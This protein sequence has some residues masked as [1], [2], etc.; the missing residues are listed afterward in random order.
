M[1]TIKAKKAYLK[2]FG[3]IVGKRDPRLNR[4]YAGKFMVVEAHDEDELPTNDGA[5][6]PWCIVG[7]NLTE[8][9][10]KAYEVWCDD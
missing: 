6:G 3:F 8:L 9:I 4:N 2:A 1:T 10:D 7:N 5:N